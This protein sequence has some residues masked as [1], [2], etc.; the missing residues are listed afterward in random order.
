M[1][2]TFRT[3]L[4]AI[5][6]LGVSKIFGQAPNTSPPPTIPPTV[7]PAAAARPSPISRQEVDALTRTIDRHVDRKLQ[8]EKV[9]ASPR[10]DDAEFIRRAYLD[11]TGKVPSATKAASFLDNASP[12]K[13]LKLIDELLFSADFGR[14]LA[15]IWQALLLPRNSENRAIPIEPFAKWLEDRFNTDQPWDRTV[16]E[17][18]TASGNSEDNKAINYWL[19]NR[20]LDKITDNVSRSFLGVQLQ[21]AQ[22]HNHPF[23]D[24][25]QDEYWGMAAFF[26][27]VRFV[28]NPLM[29][30]RRGV[31]IQLQEGGRGRPL[32]T[33]DSAKQLPPKFLADRTTQVGQSQELRL[34][35]AEWATNSRN[36]YFARA[37]VN[38]IWHQL[39]GRGIVN[40]VDDMH[41]GNVPSHPELLRELTEQFA[42]HRF[43]VKFLFRAICN[44]QAYQRTSKPIA[45]NADAGPELFA[46]MA[47]KPLTP[48][49]LFDSIVEVVG[50]V[51]GQGPM[52]RRQKSAALRGPNANPRNF[53]IT[54]FQTGDGAADPTEYQSGIPQVLRLMNGP[55]FNLAARNHPALAKSGKP[56]EVVDALFLSALARRPTAAELDRVRNHLAAGEQP[57]Q[58]YGDILWVL[59]NS[60]EFA[61]NR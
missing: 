36:P 17:L 12:D 45:G 59:L 25:K 26:S 57:R 46:R 31:A 9:W 34:V 28:G 55:M 19:A 51:P 41:D 30:A 50:F 3:L 10:A 54:F 47:V 6:F 8:A 20:E 52:G 13:R 29:A 35:F 18:L 49:Q 61:L 44:S 56:E 40:P 15:D 43:D 33:P 2:L 24:W 16:R 39:F 32:I 60:S 42:S 21:C 37:M 1:N 11:L 22:C 38:R 5:H 58:A 4:I 27:K 48:E 53:F 7:A 14:H 23:T